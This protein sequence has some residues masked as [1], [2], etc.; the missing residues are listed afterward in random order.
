MTDELDPILKAT[1]FGATDEPPVLYSEMD[2]ETARK[3]T[4]KATAEMARGIKTTGHTENR[5]FSGPDS[6]IDVRIYTP[7]R[8]ADVMPGVIYYHGG[9]WVVGSID[10]HDKVARV[11]AERIGARVIS[12]EYRLAPEHPFPAAP[13]DG[14]AALVWAHRN[15][16]DLGIDPARMAVAGDS[17]GGNIAAAVAI[18]ARDRQGPNLAAQVL[19]YPGLE[20][21]AKTKSME[22]MPDGYGLDK[23]DMDWFYNHYV[24]AGSDVTDPRLAP[25]Q[26][27]DLSGLPPAVISVA[28]FDPLHDEALIYGERLV[29]AGVPVHCFDRKTLVHGFLHLI[30]TVPAADEAFDEIAA[31]TKK[32]LN[33]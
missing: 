23:C 27:A 29:N 5:Y 17:A 21:N 4:V 25:M 26:M 12:V 6:E 31:A 2:P 22:Q 33:L 11:L 16:V 13:E 8:A 18:M 30:A 24:P 20:V 7:N 14:Y 32:L 28:G 10:T 15:A 1:L 3:Y 19:I 9:G